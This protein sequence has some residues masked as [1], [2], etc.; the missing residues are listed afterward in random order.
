MAEGVP[1]SVDDSITVG[2]EDMKE[3]DIGG[4]ED[5]KEDDIG[6]VEDMKD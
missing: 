3:D 4:V 6:G 1:S 2:V 5:M